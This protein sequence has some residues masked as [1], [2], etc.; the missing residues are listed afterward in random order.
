VTEPDEVPSHLTFRSARGDDVTV[1]V[2][3]AGPWE[4]VNQLMRARLVRLEPWGGAS[5]LRMTALVEQLSP[6]A[7]ARGYEL[8]D[9]EI[10][11]GVRLARLAE[12]VPGSGRDE[13]PRQL[14]RLVGYQAFTLDQFVLLQPYEGVPVDSVAGRLV[15]EEQQRF[16]EQMIVGVRWVGEAGL[17]HRTLSPRTVLWS[18]PH[19]QI[20][21]FSHATLIGTPRQVVGSLPW[22]AP[23]Q[24]DGASG[25]VTDRDDVWAMARLIC[26]V[27]SGFELTNR[28]QL[29]QYHLSEL[30]NDALGPV[31]SRP[32]SRELLR[33][34]RLPDPL[35]RLQ[36]GNEALRRGREQFFAVKPGYLPPPPQVPPP[37]APPPSPLVSPLDAGQP[38]N[39]HRPR[40]P[41]A[42]PAAGEPHHVVD[43]TDQ[44]VD[45][46]DVDGRR[47]PDRRG[48][49][50]R[51][52]GLDHD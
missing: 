31:E 28:T 36:S 49:W 15:R 23:E 19:V 50:R 38:A 14:P 10:L 51:K 16:I 12:R 7:R 3:A 24:R 46:R 22:A 34:L 37:Q 33:R 4:P 40:G 2:D 43:V 26:Y 9:N 13:Y 41:R 17:A 42:M 30:L 39:S 48:W 8:L 32:D 25:V 11:A 6:S 44:E 21:D 5:T 1:A 45:V 27:I 20:V 52:K 35:S 18:S 29:D 47:E